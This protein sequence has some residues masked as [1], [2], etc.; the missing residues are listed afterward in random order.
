MQPL[1]IQDP[2]WR[3]YNLEQRCTELKAAYAVSQ[4][5]I[6]TLEDEIEKLRVQME[7]LRSEVSRRVPESAQN[8]IV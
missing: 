4:S 1:A 8:W 7:E 2:G 6:K 3:V 5:R